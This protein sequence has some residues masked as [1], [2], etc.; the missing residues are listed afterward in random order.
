M[1]GGLAAFIWLPKLY[2]KDC[3]TCAAAAKNCRAL[4][5][6]FSAGSASILDNGA[7]TLVVMISCMGGSGWSSCRDTSGIATEH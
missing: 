3:L 7:A 4:S 1:Q 2:Q 5:L 6:P